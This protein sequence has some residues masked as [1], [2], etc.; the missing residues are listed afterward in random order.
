[1]TTYM[2]DLSISAE[3]LVAMKNAGHALYAF[4]AVRC[5]A[6]G[7]VPLVWFETSQYLMTTEIAWKET[8]QAYIST[9]PI[10][11]GAMVVE[12]AACDIALGQTATVSTEGTLTASPTGAPGAISIANAGQGRWTCGPAQIVDG[13]SAPICALPL[14]VDLMDVVTP[15][16]QVLLMFAAVPVNTGAAVLT[17]WSPGLLVDL[18]GAPLRLVAFDVNHG[19]SAAGADWAQPVARGSNLAELLILR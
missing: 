15:V 16:E 6:P 1:M 13:V 12:S 14:G 9:S 10:V 5:G 4:K 3:T 18:T 11:P 17:A 2:I 7:G 8:Y 19:W